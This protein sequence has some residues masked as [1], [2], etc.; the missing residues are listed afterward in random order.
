MPKIIGFSIYLF[1]LISFLT[2]MH[3]VITNFS[4][5]G[6]S[7]IEIYVSIYSIFIASSI[8][9]IVFYVFWGDK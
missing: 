5:H 7:S 4:L 6:A 3:D 9:S 1:F 2:V 8:T